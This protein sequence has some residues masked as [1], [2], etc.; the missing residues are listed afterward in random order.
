[1]LL[2]L[3]LENT[4]FSA[5]YLFLGLRKV[6]PYQY[7]YLCYCKG[8]WKGKTILD[9]LNSEF[10]SSSLEFHV[11]TILPSLLMLRHRISRFVIFNTSCISA[12]VAYTCINFL[13]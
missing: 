8:R 3:Q 4:A 1:M 10:M 5:L 6:Y 7:T 11:S 12:H 9:V 13:T 2:L